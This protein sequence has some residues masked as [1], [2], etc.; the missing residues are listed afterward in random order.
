[1]A[2]NQNV[3]YHYG[4]LGMKWGI[5]RYQNKDGTLTAAGRK[6]Y[7]KAQRTLDELSEAKKNS[8][9]KKTKNL[10]FREKASKMT[11]EELNTA[12]NRLTQE[13]RY[14]DIANSLNPP[15]PEKKNKMA[16]SLQKSFDQFMQPQNLINVATKASEFF[17]KKEKAEKEAAFMRKV[18]GFSEEELDKNLD[19][20]LRERDYINAVK[21][22]GSTN[23]RPKAFNI[24]TFIKGFSDLSDADK[25]RIKDL[26]ED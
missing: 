10:S 19:R 4:I 13:K 5:R 3:L 2:D 25:N 15:V 9:V 11:D 8:D 21:G 23:N 24:D 20:A 6:R 18:R 1:M 14:V 7:E 26:F 16:E 17:D 12:I 22:T